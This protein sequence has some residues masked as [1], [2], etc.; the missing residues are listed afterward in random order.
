MVR[1]QARGI[2]G[3]SATDWDQV[4]E[5]FLRETNYAEDLRAYGATAD[6]IKNYKSAIGNLPKA[7]QFEE[8]QKAE[9]ELLKKNSRG[10]NNFLT[11]SLNEFS[12]LGLEERQ[13]LLKDAKAYEFG[14]KDFAE[15]KLI[16]ENR[17][18]NLH[19]IMESTYNA[20]KKMFSVAYEAK[21]TLLG[22]LRRFLLGREV[23]GS[24]FANKM[25][26]SIGNETL[27]P[28]MAKALKDTGL[29]KKI[30]KSALGKFLA[31]YNNIILEGATNRFAGG[32]LIAIAQAWFLAEAIYKSAKAEGGMG[33]KARTFAE[34]FT[35]LIAMFACIPPAIMLMH[36][37][38]G[39][40]YIGMTKDQVAKYRRDLLDFNGRAM[41]GTM[42]DTE[43]I[44]GKQG[45]NK[46]LKAGV[47]NPI[48]KLLK[49]VGRIVSVGL[50]QIR[51]LDTQKVVRETYWQKIKDLFRH[52]KFGLKQMAGYPMRIILGMMIIM[53]FFSKLAVKGCHAIFGKPKNS[54]LDEGKEPKP[55]EPIFHQRL[56]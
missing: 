1:D 32:K 33:E 9:F 48:A 53:P 4:T 27:S 45:L 30:P 18:D 35:E 12:A 51:P 16:K 5:S 31:K 7:Q 55:E 44:V 15:F 37:V 54:V 50:E 25:A 13:K 23:Y 22:R 3:F 24:E 29:D 38:G 52:P 41:S 56:E 43:Y 6:E 10:E 40:Q 47:K 39:L 46:Q 36:K 34:R 11:K 26:S 17:P 20:N 19:R 21:P 28:E 49:R 8:L 42:S 2:L 14:L